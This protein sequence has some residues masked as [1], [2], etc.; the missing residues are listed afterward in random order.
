VNDDRANRHRQIDLTV[1]TQIAECAAIDPAAARLE[2]GQDRYGRA[3]WRPGH[4]AGR[5]AGADDIDRVEPF[6]DLPAH[7]RDE[8]MD[9]GV[10]FDVEQCR[11]LDGADLAYPREVVAHQVDDH[12]VFRAL[13]LARPE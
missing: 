9:L 2:P 13:L 8:L 6:A 11:H 7:G 3:L 1:K 4:R 5:E 10:G 12:D